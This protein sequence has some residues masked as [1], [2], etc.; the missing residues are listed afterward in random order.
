MVNREEKIRSFA[1]RNYWEVHADFKVDAGVY[2]G[3]YFDPDFK[4]SSDPDLKAE[5]LW[6]AEDAQKIADAVRGKRAQ[7]PRRPNLQLLPALPCMI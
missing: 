1:P 2:E 5:R 3:K 4:K 7:P 6:A